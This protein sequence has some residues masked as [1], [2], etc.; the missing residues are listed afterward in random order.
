MCHST[1]LP[2]R[3]R[4]KLTQ[5]YFK[6]PHYIQEIPIKGILDF[7]TIWMKAEMGWPTQTKHCFKCT[8]Q[9]V[10]ISEIQIRKAKRSMRN[11]PGRNENKGNLKKVKTHLKSRNT[12]KIIV[13]PKFCM[14]QFGVVPP[15]W[16]FLETVLFATQTFGIQ[17]LFEKLIYCTKPLKLKRFFYPM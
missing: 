1:A 11:I 5:S 9:H 17:N 8:K 14:Y 2:T 16:Y 3:F 15:H 10:V 7:R 13:F 4:G 12:S 6:V